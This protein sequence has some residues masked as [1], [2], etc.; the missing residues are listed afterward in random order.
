[1]KTLRVKHKMLT[2]KKILKLKKNEN[3]KIIKL[4]KT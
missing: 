4:R 2:Y 3:E 1:M